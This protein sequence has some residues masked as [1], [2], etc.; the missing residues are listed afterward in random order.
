MENSRTNAR[1]DRKVL[2]SLSSSRFSTSD[3]DYI[4]A[5]ICGTRY[6][7]TI[8]TFLAW[9]ACSAQTPVRCQCAAALPYFADDHHLAKSHMTDVLNLPRPA[10]MSEDVALLDETTR[11]FIAAE[12]APHLDKWHDDHFY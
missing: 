5:A 7:S 2:T 4:L 3:I 1:L 10:W 6:H 12:Y 11:R 8:R 9:R